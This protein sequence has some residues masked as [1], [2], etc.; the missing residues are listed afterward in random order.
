[1]NKLIIY[2]IFLFF[3][4]KITAQVNLVSNPSFELYD[5]C[6][7]SGGQIY[8]A[9]NWFQPYAVNG[10]VTLISSSDYFN[11]CSSIAGVGVPQNSVGYQIPLTGNAYAG[12]ICFGPGAFN[13]REYIETN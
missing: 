3:V 5:S 8:Y 2:I 10:N 12:I 11:S 4:T 6:P 1:M 13:Y 9:D 7:N